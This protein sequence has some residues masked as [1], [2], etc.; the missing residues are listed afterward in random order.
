MTFIT[1]VLL[2]IS[3]TGSSSNCITNQIG[4]EKKNIREHS[5]TK[6]PELHSWIT[7]FC[8]IS[9]YFRG[10][11]NFANFRVRMSAFEGTR[12][13][14]KFLC[15]FFFW[16]Q[17]AVIAEFFWCLLNKYKRFGQMAGTQKKCETIY[18]LDKKKFKKK[19]SD[20]SWILK[21]NICIIIRRKWKTWDFMKNGYEKIFSFV[22]SRFGL[23]VHKRLQG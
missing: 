2:G 10:K 8:N 17:N 1:I 22:F 9:H 13:I 11:W 14:K 3:R 5:W 15:L 16:G 18:I 12:C 21:C 6:N 4:A 19:T 7:Q 20:H 23:R